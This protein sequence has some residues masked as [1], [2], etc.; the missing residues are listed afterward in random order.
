MRPCPE[1]NS[2]SSFKLPQVEGGIRWVLSITAIFYDRRRRIVFML[3]QF[4]LLLTQM[5]A[6]SGEAHR[7]LFAVDAV[8]AGGVA[9]RA[10]NFSDAWFGP[11]HRIISRRAEQQPQA[12]AIVDN[13]RIRFTRNWTWRAIGWQI[14]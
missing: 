3:D 1:R 6:G 9:D 8:P 10:S 11:A 14:V 13:G 7:R 12:P 5:S 2:I 4:E